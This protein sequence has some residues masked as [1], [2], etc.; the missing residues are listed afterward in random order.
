MRGLK[1]KIVV[2]TGAAGGIG[3]ASALLFAEEG[4]NVVIADRR[5]TSLSNQGMVTTNP[6]RT[7]DLRAH[8]AYWQRLE[9]VG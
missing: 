5:R 2:I 9:L 1:D 7:R 3:K 8:P 6:Q 4:A